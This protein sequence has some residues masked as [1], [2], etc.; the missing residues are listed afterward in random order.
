MNGNA[1]LFWMSHLGEGTWEA[2]SKA[3]CELA[4]E[5]ERDGGNLSKLIRRTRYRLS[6]IGDV[7]FFPEKRRRWKVVEPVL[8]SL[9]ESPGQAVVCG[10]RS[11]ALNEALQS[12]AQKGQC[13]I[14]TIK[15]PS[16]PDQILIAGNP[17]SLHSIALSCRVRHSVD[18]ADELIRRFTPI[19]VYLARAPRADL[20]IGWK[21]NYFDLQALEW[22]TSPISRTACE[23]VSGYGRRMTFLPV[24]RT[25]T[26]LLPRRDAIY[27]AAALAGVPILSY[28]LASFA[29]RVPIHAPL[30]EPCAR[31]ACISSG[32]VGDISDN[33]VLY[34]PVPPRSA[35]L[36][37]V[38]LGQG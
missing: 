21:R 38:S 12:A 35:R 10:G 28:D 8:A 6:D 13:T 16:L 3:V 34:S 5:G 11:P 29:L 19:E 32:K 9:P 20:M 25:R 30:P 31:L 7:D 36:I 4:D 37:L 15:R 22:T 14:E 27:A 24:S 23:C 17:D 18:F 1:L 2:F 33:T 26:V